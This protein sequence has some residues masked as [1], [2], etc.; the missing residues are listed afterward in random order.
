MHMDFQYIMNRPDKL[1]FDAEVGSNTNTSKDGNIG[2]EMF[3]C[4]VKTWPQ[5]Q[6]TTKDSHFTV[7]GLTT[8]LGVPVSM[9]SII[10]AAKRT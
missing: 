9:C 2:G 6:E 5:I 1:I 7:L 4:K 8:A 10:F 3:L